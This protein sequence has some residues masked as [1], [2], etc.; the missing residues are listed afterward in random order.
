MLLSGAVPAV[1]IT[2]IAARLAH[3]RTGQNDRNGRL[4]SGHRHW[5]RPV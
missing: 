4:R 3:R 1:A 5:P 2:L